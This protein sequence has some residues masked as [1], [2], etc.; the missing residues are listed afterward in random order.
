M[1]FRNYI[2]WLE[3]K[4][5]EKIIN[6][7]FRTKD[8]HVWGMAKEA[9]VETKNKT[10]YLS[11]IRDPYYSS[12]MS[13]KTFRESCYNCLYAGTNRI[14]DITMGDYWGI[15]KEHKEFNYEKGVSVLLINS[16]KGMSFFEKIECDYEYVK[17]SIDKASKYNNTLTGPTKRPKERDT[18]YNGINSEDYFD[19]N[20][21]V[22]LQLKDILKLL[23]PHQL[24]AF[25][26]KRV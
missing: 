4:I 3:K 12:F 22:K 26:R 5:G 24:K 10:K 6:Y 2:K 7:N 20:L 18:I 8:R 1:L 25:I 21:R 19:K 11:S 14:A 13:A 9:K 23:I 16:K 17:S 15:L